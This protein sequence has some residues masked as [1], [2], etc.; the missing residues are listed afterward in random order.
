MYILKYEH[1]PRK[2][3]YNFKRE[4][5]SGNR[6]ENGIRKNTKESVC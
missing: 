5:A 4:T 3:K 1:I 2:N 6:E